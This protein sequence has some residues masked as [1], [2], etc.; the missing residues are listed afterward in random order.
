M[1]N[2]IV[3]SVKCVSLV[4]MGFLVVVV[5][6]EMIAFQCGRK[7]ASS[8]LVN[9]NTFR[10]SEMVKVSERERERENG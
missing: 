2:A 10:L 8:L 1:F 6:V 4:Y 3:P 9:F 5:V 7:M